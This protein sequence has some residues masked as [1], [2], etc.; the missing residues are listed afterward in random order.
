MTR[1]ALTSAAGEKWAVATPHAAASEAAASAFGAGGNA[2]DAALWAAVTLAVV[3]PH[4]CGVGGDLFALIHR[5]DG[6]TVAVNASGRAP[7]AAD[8]DA[9]ARE[10]GGA[11][12]QTGPLSITVPGAVSGWHAL[13]R[14]GARL[15]WRDA[16]ARAIG[17]ARDGVEVCGSLAA[18]MARDATALSDDAGLA[19]VFFPGGRPPAEGDMLLQPALSRTLQALAEDGPETLYGGDIGKRYAR[20][21]QAVGCP[22]TLDDLASHSAELTVPIGAPYRD[23]EILTSPPNSQGFVLLEMLCMIERLGVDPDPLGGDVETLARISDICSRDR[24]HHL[25]DPGSMRIHVSTFLDDGHLAALHEA[26]LADAYASAST[27]APDSAH[28]DGDTIA[29]VTADAEGNAVSLIQSLYAGFGSGILEP[30]TGIVAHDRGACFTLQANHPNRLEGGKR[31]AHTLMPVIALRGGEPTFVAG[32]MGG[33]AQPQI[34]AQNIARLVDIGLSADAA[35]AAPRWLLGGM[36]PVGDEPIVIAE[37]DVPMAVAARLA[38]A[39]F[40]IQTVAA[41]SED[42]GHSQLIALT[43]DGFE[44]GSDPRADGSALAG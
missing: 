29:L 14:Q 20:G 31:P 17:H 16:F 44:A 40:D 9:A 27:D 21:L 38:D 28:R 43:P 34:N 6:A 24:D 18:G 15:E 36:D 42:V 4:M 1:S 25:A 22:I 33:S 5:P 12:P 35:V 11:M 32:T 7:R 13:H 23:L 41:R 8:V 39:G 3:Y 37:A 2:V 30:S 26:V 10:G 19:E